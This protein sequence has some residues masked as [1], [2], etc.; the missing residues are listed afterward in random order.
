V[1]FRFAAENASTQ[2]A[3]VRP[4]TVRLDVAK[5]AKVIHHVRAVGCTSSNA[6]QKEPSSAAPNSG[7]TGSERLD[8]RFVD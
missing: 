1:D 7:Q 8:Q 4:E 3:G 2:L 5:L 6:K